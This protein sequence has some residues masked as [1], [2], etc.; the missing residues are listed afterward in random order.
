MF[1]QTSDV[2]LLG[3]PLL[4]WLQ[5]TS[6]TRHPKTKQ[7]SR[8]GTNIAELMQVASD[9][10]DSNSN[11][12]FDWDSLRWLR[13]RDRVHYAGPSSGWGLLAEENG[14]YTMHWISHAEGD[15]QGQ[16]R[17][18]S[19][20][21]NG[22]AQSNHLCET[23]RFCWHAIWPCCCSIAAGCRCLFV[24]RYIEAE[25]SGDGSVGLA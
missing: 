5:T 20:Q 6:A 8:A 2:C 10:G 17:D 16:R 7:A 22:W 13:E 18:W 19:R 12:L 21:E 9:I 3:F 24:S 25:C 1:T 11:K 15:Q 23:D 14:S 4:V